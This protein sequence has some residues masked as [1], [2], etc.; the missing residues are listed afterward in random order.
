MADDDEYE[1]TGGNVNCSH[2]WW[3][4][5]GDDRCKKCPAVRRKK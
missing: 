4:W 1:I 2:E 5:S 3:R